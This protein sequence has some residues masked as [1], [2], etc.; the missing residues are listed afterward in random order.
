VS[1]T[2]R[3]TLRDVDI[4]GYQVPAGSLVQVPLTYLAEHDPRWAGQVGGPLDPAA[5]NPDRMM[6]KEGAK[7]GWVMPFGHGPR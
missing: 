2:A 6:G 4:G 5:F 3:K 1:A 7:P